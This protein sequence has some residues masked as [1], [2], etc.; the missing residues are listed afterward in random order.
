M[1]CGGKGPVTKNM[2]III[3]SFCFARHSFVS[4]CV[5]F[6]LL[7]LRTRGPE[8]LS[9]SPRSHHIWAHLFLLFPQRPF[10]TLKSVFT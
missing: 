9:P 4:L 7:L 5:L 6:K 1:N 10:D 2:V 3:I 8:P